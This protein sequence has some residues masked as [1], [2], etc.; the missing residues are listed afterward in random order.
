MNSEL[1]RCLEPE[2]EPVA[3]LW[4]DEAPQG[5]LQPRPGKFVC[6]LN[7]FAE[8]ARTGRITGGD[9]TTI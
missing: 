7:L 8:T 6:I 5:A 3:L 4:T 2:I 9:C 1:V